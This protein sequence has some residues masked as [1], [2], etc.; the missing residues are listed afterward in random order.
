[1][2]AHFSLGWSRHCLGLDTVW[3]AAADGWSF[4][5]PYKQSRRHSGTVHSTAALRIPALLL[6]VQSLASSLCVY[7]G[8]LRVRQFYS[9]SEKTD[10]FSM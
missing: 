3:S 4:F 1:M 2:Q 6:S 5:H 7:V 8:F 10:C 9:T